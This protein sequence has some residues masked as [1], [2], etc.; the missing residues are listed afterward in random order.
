MKRKG[1]IGGIIDYLNLREVGL[2]EMAFALTPILS[3]YRFRELPLSLLMWLVLIA[4]VTFQGNLQK[5]RIFEPLLLFSGYW[6]IHEIVV[7]FSDDV[8]INGLLAQLIYFASVFILYPTINGPKLRGSFNWVAI[9]AMLGLLYQWTLIVRGNM[10]HPLEIPG[11]EMSES[12]LLSESSR[13]SSFFMEPAAYVEFMIFPLF[14]SLLDKK[15][16]W[17]FIIVL[18]IFLTTSTT[19]I[20]LSFIMLGT[21]MFSQGTRVRSFFMV[22]L[23]GVALFYSLTHFSAFRF[24]IEKMQNTDTETNVRLTQGITVVSTMSSSEYLFGVPYDNAYEYCV[25]RSITN[26]EYYGENVFM[27][28][29][30]EI[31]LLYGLI[32]LI[33]YSNI[34][35]KLFKKNRVLFPFLICVVA[36]WFSGG[37]G[38]HNGFAFST[39]FLLVIA[40]MY[41]KKR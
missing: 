40:E 36:M 19:G 39:V 35:I 26:I 16:I 33:F 1:Q 22:L 27:P 24:G 29:F 12:R 4:I 38:I 30:W 21:S 11:L 17:T 31:I 6:V 28:T 2:L 8:N 25:S 14:W 5:I 34:Y 32:G 37:Y 9:I 13:P 20:L 41:K 23:I 7:V 10:I 18:S 15:R 3:G